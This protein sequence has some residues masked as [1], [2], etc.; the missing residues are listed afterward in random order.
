MVPADDETTSAN[1]SEEDASTQ[2][3][4]FEKLKFWS[5]A[6]RKTTRPHD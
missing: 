5:A 3:N 1:E 6:N 4:F 2:K